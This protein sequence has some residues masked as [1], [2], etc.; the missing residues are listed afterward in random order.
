MREP[1][2]KERINPTAIDVNVKQPA[3][4]W[5]GHGPNGQVPKE[6]RSETTEKSGKVRVSREITGGEWQQLKSL[7]PTAKTPLETRIQREVHK[8]YKKFDAVLE[9]GQSSATRTQADGTKLNVTLTKPDGLAI[10]VEVPRFE[11]LGASDKRGLQQTAEQQL[12]SD[13]AGYQGGNL[14][15]RTIQD[16][17]VRVVVTGPP[18]EHVAAGATTPKS[19]VEQRRP[20]VE[21]PKVIIRTETGNVVTTEAGNTE[22]GNKDTKSGGV[23]ETVKP[24]EGVMAPRTTGEIDNPRSS[25]ATKG[26]VEGLALAL[27]Q[28]QIQNLEHAERFKAE[29]AVNELMP[30]VRRLQTAG[31]WVA[32]HAGVSE[33]RTHDFGNPVFTTA[34]Q[35]RKFEGAYIVSGSSRADVVRPPMEYRAADP[36]PDREVSRDIQE[37]METRA[38][39]DVVVEVYE[40]RQQMPVT[41][42][43]RTDAPPRNVVDVT[44]DKQFVAAYDT[45]RGNGDRVSAGTRAIQMYEAIQRG[46]HVFGRT[47]VRVG[48][49]ELRMSDSVRS[50]VEGPRQ[51]FAQSAVAGRIERLRN[52][53]ENLQPHVNERTGGFFRS[54]TLS[55]HELDN[56][57]AHLSAAEGYSRDNKFGL[58]SESLRSGGWELDGVREQIYISDYGTKPPH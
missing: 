9:A 15:N 47:T 39:R 20:A 29:K 24:A 49:T 40:P 11:S 41:E 3:V 52:E 33:P 23:R 37:R 38:F 43:N 31:N 18:P 12:N 57:R 44:S 13:L 26:G 34:D 50:T 4:D 58:A 28:A 36:G 54:G 22:T 51:L 1:Q 6:S 35:I 27:H 25:E 30:E 32:I 42:S 17:P 8:A 46:E 45:A 5:V 19:A 16:V 7:D 2:S 10:Y 55:G 48:D 53:I 56:A 14:Q 21:Q